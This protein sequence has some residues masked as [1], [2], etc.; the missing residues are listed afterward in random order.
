M[1]LKGVMPMLADLKPLAAELN[2]LSDSFTEELKQLEKELNDLNLG[3]EVE[4]T[5]GGA[6][7]EGER[8]AIDPDDVINGPDAGRWV[9]EREVVLLAFGQT[10]NGRWRLLSRHYRHLYGR[11]EDEEWRLEEVRPLLEETRPIRLAASHRIAH[12]VGLIN[13]EAKRK[14]AAVKEVIKK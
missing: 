12:L 7:V 14:I 10:S 1:V 3:I 13:D 2:Q 8:T 9:T 6:L 5:T 11:L 4:V